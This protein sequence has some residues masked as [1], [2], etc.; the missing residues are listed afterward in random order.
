MD[1]TLGIT[2]TRHW[3][4]G[5][6]TVLVAA[7]MIAAPT[8]VGLASISTGALLLLSLA[9]LLPR[10]A[11]RLRTIPPVVLGA[12]VLML[13]THA[14]ATGLSPVG[15]ARWGVWAEES[16]LKLLLAAIP[17]LMA[18]RITALQRSF[19]LLLGIAGL[20][21]I[22]GIVQRYTGIDLTRDR[23]TDPVA[24]AYMAEGFFQHHLSYGGNLLIT[25]A[26][27]LSRSLPDEGGWRRASRWAT[28]SAVLMA[29]A[30]VFTFAR[31]VQIG[32]VVAAAALMLTHRGRLRRW[33]LGAIGALSLATLALPMIRNRFLSIF[34]GSE[35][36]R[37]N[38][39]KSSWAGIKA[40]PWF[41]WGQG[42]FSEMLAAH[43]VPGFYNS[44]AHAHNE[45]LMHA[46]NA[47]VLGLAA[48]L[49]LL[50]ALLVVFWK[51][52]DRLGASGWIVRGCFAAIA[53]ISASGA[54]QVF[55]TDDEVEFAY[56]LVA[57]ATLALVATARNEG[58]EARE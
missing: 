33:G 27:A 47:G 35:A 15:G 14:L 24:G 42:H 17:I 22:Y 36:T 29:V 54:F 30:M 32:T 8:S 5:P 46:V 49:F 53:G 58:D 38:L 10:P 45:Y 41:G 12:L 2:T 43:E 26:L 28:V 56:Y 19:D 25:F 20:V 40:H 3:Y 55:L 23:H 34:D 16:W 6:A 21:A 18:G 48:Q 51:F 57:G 37:L 7:A 50:V 9:A 39:W 31:S 13:L 11:A 1:S 44:R 4:D 52:R